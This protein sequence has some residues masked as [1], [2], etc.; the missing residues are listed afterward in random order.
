[1]V[2]LFESYGFS[3]VIMV[4]DIHTKPRI[5]HFTKWF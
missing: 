5:V 2:A 3:D 4:E 1:V